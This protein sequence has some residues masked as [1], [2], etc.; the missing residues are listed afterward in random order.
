MIY[1][2]T[3]FN[4]FDC[5]NLN[6]EINNNINIQGTSIDK[7]A[8][9][10]KLII[11]NTNKFTGDNYNN[12]LDNLSYSTNAYI[13]EYLT[14]DEGHI[15][16][17][18]KHGSNSIVY[19]SLFKDITFDSIKNFYID[20]DC[21]DSSNIK[22][23]NSNELTILVLNGRNGF[24]INY[25]NLLDENNNLNATFY[26]DYDTELTLKLCQL[27][28]YEDIEVTVNINDKAYLMTYN[29]LANIESRPLNV[30]DELIVNNSIIQ[31]DSDINI[32]LGNLYVN[33]SDDGY[34]SYLYTHGKYHYWKQ[35]LII[36]NIYG[37]VNIILPIYSTYVENQ[38]NNIYKHIDVNKVKTNSLESMI[39]IFDGLD[40]ES[41]IN[42]ITKLIDNTS[43]STK[44][45]YM[46]RSQANIIGDDN[47]AAAV[48]KNYEFAIIEN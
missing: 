25:R 30:N 6:I 36:D 1:V 17:Y 48:A 19:N 46:Y 28:K 26:I 23:T 12:I 13:I 41:T 20:K 45:I 24:D 15:S 11:D 29:K 39:T 33:C 2:D 16:G 18:Y 3:L 44:T 34:L 10:K 35:L 31:T 27:V 38:L 43:E 22:F 9:Y 32:Q 14:A 47:I 40:D 5:S 4:D 21:I 7:Y 37:I 42:L 8:H